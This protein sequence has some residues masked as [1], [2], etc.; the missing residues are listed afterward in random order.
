MELRTMAQINK[1]MSVIAMAALL[2]R[3]ALAG[4]PAF[5]QA[6]EP[7]AP[8]NQ[9]GAM[10]GTMMHDGMMGGGMMWGMG[11]LGLLVI[12]LLGLGIAALVKYLFRSGR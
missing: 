4:A 9:G 5:A 12:V 3:L 1:T 2:G 7:A 6:N 11:L 8:A 10:M